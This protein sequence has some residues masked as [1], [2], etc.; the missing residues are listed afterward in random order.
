[1]AYGKRLQIEYKDINQVDTRVEIWQDGYAGAVTY[2]EYAGAEVAC[3]VAW[4]DSG[5]K[6]LPLVY[7]S[8]VTLFFDAEVDFEFDDFF[9]ADSRKNRILVYKNNTLF[10]VAYGEADTW[11]EP[12][13]PAP[14]EV[15]FTGYDGLGLLKDED[16]LTDA[17]TV[18][19]GFKTP[20]EILSLILQK[21]PSGTLLN[22]L[23]VVKKDLATYSDMNCYEVLQALFRGCRILQRSGEWWVISND[24]WGAA[25]FD[26]YRHDFEG[27]YIEDD[28][29]TTE[30]SGFWFEGQG[31]REF[32][33]AL[34]EI[35]V[36][37]NFGYKPNLL[38]NSDFSKIND[39]GDFDNWTAVGVTV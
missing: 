12:L 32:L 24:K 17:K 33:P 6:Q 35:Q 31:N 4:G 8:Q 22:P 16:F 2:R 26:Y 5:T 10:H 39:A 19:E 27:T 37:Q 18:Y 11:S 13:I 38:K 34:K 21:T 29:T 9:T 15:S 20:L 7:G 36:I 28:S 1:M 30:F 25:S 14:F 23:T 3:E